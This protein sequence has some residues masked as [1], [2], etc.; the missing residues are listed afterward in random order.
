MINHLIATNQTSVVLLDQQIDFQ[1]RYHKSIH[2]VVHIHAF[3]EPGDFYKVAFKSGKYDSIELNE[4]Q[5]NNDDVVD[6]SLRI[7]L[8]S[9]RTANSELAKLHQN[10]IINKN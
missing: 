9:K 2:Q 6:Y 1:S 8:K 4:R 3:L 10:V 5:L 7:A